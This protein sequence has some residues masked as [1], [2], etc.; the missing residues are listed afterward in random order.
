MN[1][2]EDLTETFREACLSSELIYDGQVV[3]LYRDTVRLPDGNP[4][5][6]EHIRH[7]GAV[8]VLPLDADGFVYC[9]RQFR[10][11]FGAVLT[12]LPAGKL[13]GKG[14]DRDAA[15]RRELREETGFTCG[16]LTRLGELYPSPAILDERITF[17]LAEDLTPGETDPDDDEFLST[18]RMPFAELAEAVFSG[19]IPDA[20]TQIAVMRVAELLRRRAAGEQEVVS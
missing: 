13:D 17:Y 12:E 4:A 5:L 11:P 6:R 20:K 1:N 10:Y 3:H 18:V 2:K 14:E 15:A 7:V 8:C 19:K 16:K 9:V